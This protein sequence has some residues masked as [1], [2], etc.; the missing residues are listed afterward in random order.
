[1]QYGVQKDPARYNGKCKRCGQKASILLVEIRP[2]QAVGQ[3]VAIDESLHEFPFR[4]GFWVA[5][6]HDCKGE[7]RNLKL[8]RVRGVYNPGKECNAKC[9]AAIGHDCECRCGGKN[10]G[11][12]FSVG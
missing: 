9:L 10:H 3:D 1:M 2:S 7:V 5:V 8:T 6:P 11:A 4:D 12:G